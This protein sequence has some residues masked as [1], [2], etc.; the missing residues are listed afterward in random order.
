MIYNILAISDIHWG[1][2]EAKRL[3]ENLQLVLSTIQYLKDKLDMVVICGDYFDYRLQLNSKSA[4]LSLQWMDELVKTCKE[5]NVKRIR[6][7]KGTQE[8]DN[9]QLEAFRSYED[10]TGFFRIFNENTYEETLPELSC[11][12]CPDETIPTKEYNMKYLSNILQVADLGFFHGSFDIVLPEIVVQM[13]EE[14]NKAN[15]IFEYELFSKCIKGL[16]VSGHWHVGSFNNPVLYTGSFD[17][18]TFGEEEDKGFII[19]Q[20]NTEDHTYSYE[21]IVNENALRY[22]T[23]TI[24]TSMYKSA[25]DYKELIDDINEK[26]DLENHHLRVVIQKS[27]DRE[28]DEVFI[29][30]FKKFFVNTKNVKID[31]KDLI[32]KAKKKEKKNTLEN[33]NQK[34]GFIFDKNTANSELERISETIQKFILVQKDTSVS[35]DDISRYIKPYL[36]K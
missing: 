5:S 22:D 33:V 16:I 24:D 31:V 14:S 2:I 26:Y 4:L 19:L 18:W 6:I 3:Y 25:E 34:Y 15:V 7:V 23:I 11:L 17:R 8:H 9:N 21:K 1:A 13:S 20:Y 27:T 32:K 10:E 12:Y 35:I 28:E 29:S 36:E 30:A